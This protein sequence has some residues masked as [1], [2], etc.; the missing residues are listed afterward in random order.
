LH[1]KGKEIDKQDKQEKKKKH[2]EK[3]Y[4][5]TT[6]VWKGSTAHSRN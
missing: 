3:E 6:A 2:R 5:M 1:I 4:F